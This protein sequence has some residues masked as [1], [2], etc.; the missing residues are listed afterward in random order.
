MTE[1]TALEDLSGRELANL[2][3][4][5]DPDIR[6]RAARTIGRRNRGIK[7]R[8]ISRKEGEDLRAALPFDRRSR[9]GRLVAVLEAALLRQIGP[10]PN[11][12]ARAVVAQAV[13]LKLRLNALDRR[14]VENGQTQSV[15]DSRVY[16]AWSNSY[17]RALKLLGIDGGSEPELD[18]FA[19]I[20]AGRRQVHAEKAGRATAVPSG[21]DPLTGVAE[22]A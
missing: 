5:P 15:H 21:I 22:A 2:L 14:F 1:P 17:V 4:S 7:K 13:Q 12:A 11:P 16:L 10:N 18:A 6:K 20:E 3:R 8:A 19:A 9:E